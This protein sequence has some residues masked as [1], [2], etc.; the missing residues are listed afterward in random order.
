MYDGH[1]SVRLLTDGSTP[2]IAAR[3][4][5]QAYGDRTGGNPQI[6]GSDDTNYG[7]SG[8]Q[9][10][11]GSQ[12]QYLR[13]RYYDT[14]NGRFNRMDPYQGSPS[15]P[16]SLH[17]YTYA[18]ANPV[19]GTDPSGLFTLVSIQLASSIRTILTEV[20]AA[21]GGAAI[22]A[23]E[24]AGAGLSVN[25]ALIQ[26]FAGVALGLVLGVAVGWVLG[27]AL[28]LI[29]GSITR[30]FKRPSGLPEG[31]I[32]SGIVYRG[33]RPQHVDDAWSIHAA[34]IATEFRYSGS[35]RGGIYAGTSYRTAYEEVAAWG[36][37]STRRFVQKR[38]AVENILDLTDPAVRQQLG[39]TLEDLTQ[40]TGDQTADYFLTN[41]IGD[42]A[43][44]RYDGMLVPSARN[45]GGS[46]L[47]MFSD[48]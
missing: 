4:D 42:F 39:V 15:D 38:V 44:T 36:N 45:P 34:N 13:A 41:S 12:M 35:G 14:G 23:A 30:F 6:S 48:L 37:P 46:N 1:G 10:D 27:R 24:A 28:S 17:K 43:R 20:Y 26:F 9:F 29:R 2:T 19:M 33:V 18:H 22:Y 3:Y 21:G 25:Q 47:V 16:Q 40:K 5:Y 31:K 32:F 7:Y 11:T 8:E